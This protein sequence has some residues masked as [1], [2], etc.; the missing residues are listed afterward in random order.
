[1]TTPAAAVE[2][3]RQDIGEI[4]SSTDER[5][6]RQKSRDFYWYS[7]ILTPQ[8]QNCVADVVVQPESEDEIQAVVAAA[9]KHRIPVTVRGGGTGNYGQSVPLR[10]GIV[11]DMTRFDKVIA[12]E[13]GSIRVRAGTVIESALAAALTTGQQLM[14]YPSTMESATIGGYLGGGFAGIGSVRHGI[15]RDSGMIQ[16]L[17]VMTLEEQPRVLTLTGDDVGFVFHAWGTTGIILEA[18]LKLVPAVRWIDCIATF[19]TYGD[20]IAFGNAAFASDL[21]IFLLSA[22]ERRF[23]P[24][25]KRLS[26]YF[27]GSRH[28][29]FSMVKEE[30]VDRFFALAASFHGE[31][32]LAVSDA[33]SAAAKLRRI[34]HTAFNHTTLMALQVDRQW[35]YLQVVMCNPFPPEL[36]EEQIKRF[37]DEVLMHHEYTKEK[38]RCRIGGLPLIRYTSE[39]RLYEIMRSFEN[40]GCTINNPHIFKLEDGGRFDPEGHKMVFRK[41]VDPLGLMNP[42]KLR[43][44]VS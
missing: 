12:V 34:H 8:L 25:Y 28:A 37:G 40:D 14:M 41:H 26:R 43:S 3:F 6:L 42:G 36:V 7:P 32:A 17:K 10:G 44:V 24:F 27:D 19:P 2:Q 29:M 16:S 22:V 39:Q 13:R 15:I 23:A 9:A 33:E 20:V 30:D 1:M 4:T 21:D 11:L 35:T 38:G 18:Q 31:R 5:V